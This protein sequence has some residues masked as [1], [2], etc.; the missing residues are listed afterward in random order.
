MDKSDRHNAGNSQNPNIHIGIKY[1]SARP[2]ELMV[3]NADITK[4]SFSIAQT[5]QVKNKP[6]NAAW[7]KLPW[8][9]IPSINGRT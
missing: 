9:D 2:K 8:K 6:A 3:R 1:K 7:K 5:K 4:A